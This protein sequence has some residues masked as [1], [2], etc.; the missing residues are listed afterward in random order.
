MSTDITTLA[1]AW[2]ANGYGTNTLG[3]RATDETDE[4]AW[5]KFNSGNA[6]SNTP[7]ISVTYNTKPGA[8]TPLSPLTGAAT[9]DTTP[10]LSA[11]AVD[12]DGN[13]VR[14]TFEVWK[15][16]GTAALQ[17]GT[18]AYVASGATATWT[19]GTALAQGSYKWRAAV[20]DGQDWNGT[21][22][23]WQAFTVDTTKPGAPFVSSTDYP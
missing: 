20:Y 13:T 12:A 19:P 7:Y 11:K 10:T 18:S 21:W 14:L 1:A 16:D 22:S 17:S 23:A 8:A 15:S 6:A 9:N 3:I 5:K 4:F 2:A